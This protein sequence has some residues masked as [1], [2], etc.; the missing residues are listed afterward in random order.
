MHSVY[1]QIPYCSLGH[2]TEIKYDALLNIQLHEK[3]IKFAPG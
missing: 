2:R 3:Y 1:G